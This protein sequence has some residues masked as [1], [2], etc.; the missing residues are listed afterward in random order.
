MMNERGKSD[1]LIV[2]ERLS[3]KAPKGA[4]EAAE[5]S[6]LAKGNLL[7]Q[8]THRTQSRISVPSA[9]ERVRNA[10][11]GDRR[12]RLT[13][14]MH[15]VYAPEMLACCYYSVNRGSAAG[16]DGETWQHYGEKL[17]ENLQD[18]SERLKRGAYRAKPEK[19]GQNR[20]ILYS[21]RQADFLYL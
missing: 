17:V 16:I 7:G 1:N 10:V 8:N 5:G 9:L 20:D 6:G 3:N 13:A 4:A 15:H 14:L 2:P 11:K 12:Q 19:G 18:L 21:S